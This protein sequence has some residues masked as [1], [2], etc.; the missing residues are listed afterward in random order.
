MDFSCTACTYLKK[1]HMPRRIISRLAT[2][3]IEVSLCK[4]KKL[5]FNTVCNQANLSKAFNTCNITAIMV[6]SIIGSNWNSKSETYSF[7]ATNHG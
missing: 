4:E 3:A 7:L 2:M 6:K 1:F 5:K